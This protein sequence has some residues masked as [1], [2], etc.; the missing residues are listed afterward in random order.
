MAGKIVA[1]KKLIESDAEDYKAFT[2]EIDELIVKRCELAKRWGRRK[3][4]VEKLR[5]QQAPLVQPQ[6][7]PPHRPSPLP[8]LAFPPHPVP[9]IP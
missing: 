8:R 2:L 4:G 1:A 6:P 3:E 7:P 5:T 9:Y